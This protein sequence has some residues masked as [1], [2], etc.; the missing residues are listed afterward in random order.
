LGRNRQ[1]CQQGHTLTIETFYQVLKSLVH[2][3]Q[4]CIASNVYAVR[5]NRFRVHAPDFVPRGLLCS[6]RGWKSW[7][8]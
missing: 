7:S 3:L 5:I 4:L 2:T 8:C 1:H 6:M